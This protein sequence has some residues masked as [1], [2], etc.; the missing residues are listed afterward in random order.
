MASAPSTGTKCSAGKT[1]TCSP[2]RRRS[3]GNS[4]TELNAFDN[5]YFEICNEPYERGGLTKEW[6]DQIVA[7]II[8]A[9]SSLPKKHLIAQGFPPSN[10]AIAGLNPNVSILNFHAASPDSVR[11]NYH[12]EQGH[13]L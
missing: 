6:N 1:K 12:L 7:A 10:A 8:E 2:R 5:L 4:S 11:L 9:E 3:R 13:R